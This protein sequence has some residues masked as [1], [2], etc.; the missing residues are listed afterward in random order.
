[1]HQQNVVDKY[2][3]LIRGKPS[4]G[5]SSVSKA[6][7]SF[8]D[9]TLVDPDQVDTKSQSYKIFLPRQTKNPANNVKLY[10][11]LYGLAET[12]IN[13][14]KNVIWTQPWSRM[15]EIE[16]TIRNF[17]YYLTELEG[18]VW[19]TNPDEVVKMLPFRFLVAE[20]DVDNSTSYS[21]WFK[22]NKKQEGLER[23][24]KTQKLF[25]PY[26]L[27]TPF[28]KLDGK[29]NIIQNAQKI[30]NFIKSEN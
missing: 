8:T 12:S 23:L 11:Y 20:I 30:L 22:D 17:G 5:K 16:L 26:I 21:R 10:C 1:M 6:L 18:N 19:K 28:V 25:Q 3:L 24:E 9:F 13:S 27:P 4:S 29:E 2:C 15:A 14:G 7:S